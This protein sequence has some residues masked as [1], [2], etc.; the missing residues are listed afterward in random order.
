MPDVEI[1]LETIDVLSAISLV[2][3]VECCIEIIRDI[4]AC[5]LLEDVL[6]ATI[7]KFI[8][9]IRRIRVL[10][11]EIICQV[12]QIVVPNGPNPWK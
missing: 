7:Q 9:R 4:L 1:V 10:R 3:R 11:V 8:G 12:V 5:L 6:N 2:Q